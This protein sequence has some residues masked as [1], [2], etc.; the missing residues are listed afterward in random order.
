MEDL[1]HLLSDAVA[2]QIAAGEVIQR[3]ASAVKELLENAVDAGADNIQLIIKDSGRTLIQVIDNGKGMSFNDSRLC[4]ERHATS[5]ISTADDLFHINT[6]GFRGEALASIAAISQVELKSKQIGEKMGTLVITEGSQVKEHSLTV[7]PDGTSIS[8]KNLFF[9]VPA[10]RNFLKSDSIEFSHIEEEFNRVALIHNNISF[11]L[12]HQG[13]LVCRLTPS[14]FKQRIVNLFGSHFKDK[15]Y[16]IEQNSDNIRINGFIA[17]PENAKKKKS[18]QYLFINNRFVRHNLLNYAIE[19]AYSELIP[20]GYRPAYFIHLELDPTT[21][22]INISPTKIDVKLQDERL[23][24]GFLNS[25]VKKSLGTMSLTPRLD[26]EYER[27]LD[28][29]NIAQPSGEISP[30]PVTRTPHYNPFETISPDKN[31]FSGNYQQD[32]GKIT[33]W[34][35]FM[36]GIKTET[37][38]IPSGMNQDNE[39]AIET[40]DMDNTESIPYLNIANKYLV[41]KLNE[42]VAIIDIINA[43]ERILYE[44]YLEALTKQSITVQQNLFPETITLTAANAEILQELKDDFHKLGYDIEPIGRTQFAVNGTPNNDDEGSIA[45]IIENILESFK[46]NQLQYR[47]EKEKN[48]ALSLSRQKRSFFKPI[49]NS[50]EVRELLRQL[51]DCQITNTT[52]TGKKI[53]HILSKEILDSF[54]K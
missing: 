21:I 54:F 47:T 15:L 7:A 36:K 18:E 10:R 50:I 34:E 43:R 32:K 19:T 46:S 44:Y 31:S 3:P 26:F 39:L 28:F 48:I 12:F 2:N 22:D 53:I 49:T 16:P 35:E 9:N 5:K 20:E 25:T 6:K 29:G 52:P 1:I 42:S 30:P 27:G 51:F 13:K 45:Q 40:S 23:I 11:S 14:N 4:F 17:K 8:V 37:V 38:D 33:G 24:F 41:I